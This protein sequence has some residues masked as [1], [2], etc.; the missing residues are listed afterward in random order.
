MSV[1]ATKTY[2]YNGEQFLLTQ[3]DKHVN[4]TFKHLIG[5]V[6]VRAELNDTS[7]PY[8]Y[9]F[10]AKHL[11]KNGLLD[12]TSTWGKSFNESLNVLCERLIQKNVEELQQKEATRNNAVRE[13]EKFMNPLPN[14]LTYQPKMVTSISADDN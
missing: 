12:G 3:N 1:K 4:V 11:S 5:Y 7:S 2:E 10:D 14:S 8:L 9:T 13:M 6:G